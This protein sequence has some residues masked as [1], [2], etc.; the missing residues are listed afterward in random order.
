M[1]ISRQVVLVDFDEKNRIFSLI[2]QPWLSVLA[3]FQLFVLLIT[4]WMFLDDPDARG[5]LL[6][7]VHKILY[8]T[9]FVFIGFIDSC[10]YSEIMEWRMRDFISMR[11]FRK[12]V[13]GTSTYAMKRKNIISVVPSRRN[14]RAG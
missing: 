1:V 10:K 8:D 11:R 5:N 6:N 7:A 9:E 2:M 12:L 4:T 3:V 14:A 13:P